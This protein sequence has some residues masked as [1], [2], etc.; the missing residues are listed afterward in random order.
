MYYQIQH[1]Y[2]NNLFFT[3]EKILVHCIIKSLYIFLT[4]NMDSYTRLVLV[5]PQEASLI[6]TMHY[7]ASVSVITC[8]YLCVFCHKYVPDPF[9]TV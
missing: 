8:S 2:V 4:T 1:K 5:S 3:E 7:Q 9:F 6:C